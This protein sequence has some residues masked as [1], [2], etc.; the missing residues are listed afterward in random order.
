MDAA[1]APV[2]EFVSFADKNGNDGAKSFLLR[3]ECN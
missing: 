1:G 2:H 3:M